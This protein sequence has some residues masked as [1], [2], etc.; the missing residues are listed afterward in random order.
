MAV[1]LSRAAAVNRKDEAFFKTLGGRIAATRKAQGLTQIQLAA[2][3]GIAQQTLAH[4][5]VGRLRLPASMLPVLAEGLKVS[6]EELVGQS[7][8][9]G[10]KRGPASRLAQQVERISQLPLSKQRFVMELLDT[11]LA[12]HPAPSIQEH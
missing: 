11:V 5:E 1:I 12:Q 2:L 9:R 8:P 7:S 6:V 3:L 10:H 4:Y